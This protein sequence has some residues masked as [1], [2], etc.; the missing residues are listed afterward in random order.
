MY[1][2]PYRFYTNSDGKFTH[3]KPIN[4]QLI[5]EINSKKDKKRAW[6]KLS[7]P[8]E[9]DGVVTMTMKETDG[10]LEEAEDVKGWTNNEYICSIIPPPSPWWSIPPFPFFPLPFLET[11]ICKFFFEFESP[12]RLRFTHVWLFRQEF[13]GFTSSILM[14]LIFYLSIFII[15]YVCR[16]MVACVCMWWRRWRVQLRL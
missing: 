14:F 9:E 13:L 16:F 5:K 7:L 12:F 6:R 2:T 10:M 4:N 3:M 11:H 8:D 15:M 1:P